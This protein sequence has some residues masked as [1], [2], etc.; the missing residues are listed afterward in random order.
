MDKKSDGQKPASFEKILIYV[1]KNCKSNLKK[2]SIYKTI[3]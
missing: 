3:K 2:I 1:Q